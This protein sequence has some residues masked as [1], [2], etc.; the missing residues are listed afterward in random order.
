V[1][2]ADLLGL[3]ARRETRRQQQPKLADNRLRAVTLMANSYD[4]TRRAVQFLRHDEGD[5]DLITPSLYTARGVRRRDEV[6]SD[7]PLIAIPGSTPAVGT[8]PTVIGNGASQPQAAHSE[9]AVP[10]A[11][12]VP[13]G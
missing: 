6:P 13:S 4:Q 12:V 5:V 10:V 7:E 3:A 9:P 11:P 2:A 8:G 1:L